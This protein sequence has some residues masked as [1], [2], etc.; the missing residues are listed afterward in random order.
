MVEIYDAFSIFE[1]MK[2][3]AVSFYELN[4]TEMMKTWPF[5]DSV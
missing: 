3:K 5:A 1:W 4:I 2:R